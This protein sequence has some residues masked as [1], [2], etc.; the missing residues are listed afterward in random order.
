MFNAPKDDSYY[1]FTYGIKSMPFF[2][3][4]MKFIW[5][6]KIR[7]IFHEDKI[8]II[9]P[10]HSLG[11]NSIAINYDPIFYK[12][13]KKIEVCRNLADRLFNTGTLIV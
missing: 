9:N 5:A 7:Y 10:N 13:I 11:S 8:E 6:R 12:K 3:L 4:G 2:V 1:L